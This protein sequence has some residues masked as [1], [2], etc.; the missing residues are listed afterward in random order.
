MHVSDCGSGR[1][2]VIGDAR[3]MAIPDQPS[4]MVT[5][6]LLTERACH[7]VSSLKFERLPTPVVIVA[8][9]LL[10]LQVDPPHGWDVQPLLDATIGV[11]A[12][13]RA[14]SK[15]I[16]HIHVYMYMHGSWQM[17]LRVRRASQPTIRPDK[18][19]EL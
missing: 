10:L 12:L 5:Y 6:Q 7:L 11:A 19:G 2:G 3:D 18:R 8:S 1:S 17:R 16:A 9:A 14:D 4:V 15:A 13:A